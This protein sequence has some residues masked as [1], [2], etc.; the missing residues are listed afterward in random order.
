VKALETTITRTDVRDESTM[1]DG[2]EVW[3]A[4]M[5]DADPNEPVP[6]FPEVL[7]MAQK[8]EVST[9]EEYALMRAGET[10]IGSYRLSMP[11]LDNLELVEL[12]LG[13]DPTHQGRGHGRSLLGHALA[14]CAELGRHQVLGAVTEPASEG[15]T[16]RA[17]RFAEAA[18]AHRALGDL[19]RTLDLTALDHE[20]L[21]SLRTQAEAASAGY[22]L[23]HWAGRCPDELV[24]GYAAL[25]ARMSTD[26][27][28]GDLG[29]EPEKWDAARVREVET[30][31]RAQGRFRIATVA[32]RIDY[33]ALV[34]MTDICVTKHDPPN[35]FQWDTL[36][37]KEDRGHRLGMLVKLANLALLLEQAPE[38]KRIHTWNADVNRWMIAIN[39]A[40]G[41][42]VTAR[43]SGWRLDLP[44]PA[45]VAGATVG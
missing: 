28:M 31:H 3:R 44:R 33:G 43:E 6:M 21:A 29:I 24:D 23:V 26:A 5:L 37:R 36:V 27:P 42:R 25:V 22:E 19:R 15:E 34:A 16:N 30:L 10:P 45:A 12:D 35:A 1:R 9:R 40:M 39:E 7:A 18:G 4:A 17:M 2:Y 41:F 13:I 38:A 11:L 20:R 32:R 14:R 8:P